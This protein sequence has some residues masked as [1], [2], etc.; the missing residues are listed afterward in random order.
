MVISLGL[1]QRKSDTP[2]KPASLICKNS[3]KQ[4]E[5]RRKLYS[6]LVFVILWVDGIG[7]TLKHTKHSLALANFAIRNP[8]WQSYSPRLKVTRQAVERAELLGAIEHSKETC[9]IRAK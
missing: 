7:M 8:G 9:Q 3:V 1:N 6:E 4:K 5:M 2:S